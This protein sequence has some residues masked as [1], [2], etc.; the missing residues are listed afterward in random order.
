MLRSALFLVVTLLAAP[1]LAGASDWQELAPGVHARLI[2]SGTVQNGRMLAGL[3]IAMPNSTNTYWR[4]PGET[5]I[6]TTLDVSA[7]SGVANVEIQWPFPLI[8]ETQGYRD[9]VYRGATV[10]PF[11]LTLGASAAILDI[12]ATLGVCEE[13]CVPVMTRFTLALDSTPDPAQA[14]RLKQALAMTPIDWREEANAVGSI[15]LA[16]AGDGIELRDLAPG[17]DPERLIAD[18]GDPALLF[19]SPQKSPDAAIWTLPLLSGS[20]GSNLVGRTILLTFLTSSG[21]Y[22]ARATVAPPAN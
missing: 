11:E 9:F 12:A 6:P 7:S 22:T 16:P 13:I 10:I 4:I 5:G 19:G 18:A 15:A 21:A 2:S 14:I 20:G 17:I 8:E 3:E 1:A